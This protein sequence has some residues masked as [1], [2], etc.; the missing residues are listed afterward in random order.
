MDAIGYVD[1]SECYGVVRRKSL[2][3]IDAENATNVRKFGRN[4][5]SAPSAAAIFRAASAVTPLAEK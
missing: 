3:S 2:P 5:K 4:V 1:E